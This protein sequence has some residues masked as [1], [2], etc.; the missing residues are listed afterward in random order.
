MY[1][2]SLALALFL[3]KLSPLCPQLLVLGTLLVVGV[4]H[5]LIQLSLLLAEHT[6]CTVKILSLL[7][8]LLG[9]SLAGL[10]LSLGLGICV[11]RLDSTT[12]KLSLELVLPLLSILLLLFFI[13]FLLVG[14]ET[15]ELI[16]LA[17]FFRVSNIHALSGVVNFIL[18][19][20]LGLDGLSLGLLLFQR[21]SGVLVGGESAIAKNGVPANT[22]AAERLE[23]EFERLSWGFAREIDGD[24]GEEAVGVASSVGRLG[25][26]IT[27][28]GCRL[29]LV[30][31]ATLLLSLHLGRICRLVVGIAL[32]LLD[33]LVDGSLNLGVGL[34]LRSLQC[35]LLLLVSADQ[36]LALK[37]ESAELS[38]SLILSLVELGRV[39]EAE[40]GVKSEVDKAKQGHVELN[41]STHD[42]E[43]DIADN[44]LVELVSVDEGR[45]ALADDMVKSIARLS[46]LLGSRSVALETGGI[47]DIASA[48]RTRDFL[49]ENL[50]VAELLK[51]RLMEQVLDV[52]G[53]VEGRRAGG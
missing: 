34:V 27:T 28:G 25:E 39:L 52:L 3:F 42:A 16:I 51:Q 14:R 12:S 35:L 44:A 9:K 50:L 26:N 47:S 24:V 41:E 48:E 2:S 29:E 18:A 30:N 7:L 43:V 23:E 8:G 5:L 45:V 4:H 33:N 37:G 1:S 53:V 19:V 11:L 13:L 10:L 15:A 46:S 31:C 6:L 20:A 49:L 36:S 32:D 40:S 38:T 22:P 21:N 17:L